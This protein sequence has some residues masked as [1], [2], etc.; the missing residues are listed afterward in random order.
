MDDLALDAQQH[1]GALAGLRRLDRAARAER[2]LWAALPSGPAALSVL[3]LAA[4]G[5]EPAV[6]LLQRAR[7]AGRPLTV[8]AVDRSPVALAEAG[9]RARRAR[10]PVHTGPAQ[11]APPGSLT[12]VQA[13]L[14]EPWPLPRYDVVMCSLF[15]HHLS[16]TEALSLL[17]RMKQHAARM[18]LVHDLRRSRRGWWLAAVASTL[19]T[20]SQVVRH[21]ALRSVEAAF[22]PAEMGFLAGRAGLDSLHASVAVRW[23][24]RLLLRWERP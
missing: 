2:F 6:P 9:D 15:L 21:D 1:R 13:D 22:S 17:T 16:D 18:V 10:I 20:R 11:D 5:G 14:L 24:E 8:T 4:G 23:P 7:R 12:L 3:D 19:L